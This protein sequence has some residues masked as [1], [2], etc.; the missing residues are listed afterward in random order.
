VGVSFSFIAGDVQRAPRWVQHLGMEWA[1]RLMQEPGRLWRR[2]LIEDTAFLGMVLR[3]YWS[4]SPR[5]R[6]P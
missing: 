4:G 1:H 3:A 2:Y 6:R 5:T